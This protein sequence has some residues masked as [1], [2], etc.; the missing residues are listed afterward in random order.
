MTEQAMKSQRSTAVKKKTPQPTTDHVTLYLDQSR[1]S[2]F[3]HLLTMVLF[4]EINSSLTIMTNEI[5]F[6]RNNIELYGTEKQFKKETE[7]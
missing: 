7:I 3:N 4:Y 6:L 1:N 2:K 5:L